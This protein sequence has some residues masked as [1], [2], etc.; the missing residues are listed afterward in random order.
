MAKLH[1]YL[2][3][4]GNCKEAMS[5]YKEILG[6]ELTL[7]TAGESP[8]ADQM[9]AKYHDQI[10]HSA[11]KNDDY[12]IMA[13]DMVPGIYTEGNDVHLALVC[14]SEDEINSLFKKL[15]EEGKVLQP[16]NQMFFGLMGVLV[17]KFG[18]RWMLELD[19]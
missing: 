12:E 3:F 6:G 15:S 14:K 5:F 4:N 8:V 16:L 1:P 7:M 19:K 18:K 2:T 13:T 11:L 9:P 17:D 10:L